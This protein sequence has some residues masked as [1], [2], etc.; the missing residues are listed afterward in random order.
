LIQKDAWTTK[1]YLDR[2]RR[3]VVDAS[4]LATLE[5]HQDT[6]K[7][8]RNLMKGYSGDLETLDDHKNVEED[9]LPE[10]LGLPALPYGGH[11]D[12]STR[13]EVYKGYNNHDDASKMP[14]GDVGVRQIYGRKCC[15]FDCDRLGRCQSC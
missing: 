15:R 7:D 14:F 3:N 5:N 2:F 13:D 8:M 6:V 12:H 1:S 4:T 9:L 11:R 10:K